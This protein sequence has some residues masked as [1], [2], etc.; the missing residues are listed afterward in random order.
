M[1]RQTVV[2]AAA[3]QRTGCTRPGAAAVVVE[4]HTALQHKHTADA[5]VEEVQNAAVVARTGCTR[6]AGA[7]AAAAEV[8]IVVAVELQQHTGCTLAVGVQQ[9]RRGCTPAAVPQEERRGCTLV[10][11]E[12]AEAVAQPWVGE[13]VA[14]GM[15]FFCHHPPSQ[16]RA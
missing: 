10:L 8:H 7:T 15:A 16:N 11:V 2:A 14:F 9:E 12:E 1:Q 3:V 13:E 4:V 5:G 6:P